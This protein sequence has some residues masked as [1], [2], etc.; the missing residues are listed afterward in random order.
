MKE[1]Y[2]EF[3]LWKIEVYFFFL[4]VW[5]WQLCL[6]KCPLFHLQECE[7]A[8]MSKKR[9]SSRF[10]TNMM[11]GCVLILFLVNTITAKP[12]ENK[13]KKDNITETSDVVCTYL[14][15]HFQPKLLTK[16]LM[17]WC[18][19]EKKPLLLH[20]S[21]G[22]VSF[23]GALAF[24]MVDQSQCI[25]IGWTYGKTTRDHLYIT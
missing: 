12:V 11:K 5:I 18:K 4:Q 15:F 9:N 7:T 6:R 19:I 23:L 14:L 17:N 16:M 13:D 1:I 24:Q 8:T 3:T 25:F 20:L 21:L 22:R 10:C 2:D